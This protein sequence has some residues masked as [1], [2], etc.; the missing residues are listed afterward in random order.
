M[1]DNNLRKQ[2]IKLAYTNKELR[3]HLLPILKDAGST[4]M[5]PAGFDFFE[6]EEDDYVDKTDPNIR[7]FRNLKRDDRFRL[8]GK[9]FRVIKDEGYVK[10]VT[11]AGSAETKLF[12]AR[13]ENLNYVEGNPEV[14][15]VY[16]I[17]GIGQR[18]T[19]TPY[20]KPCRISLV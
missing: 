7:I 3:P 12:E 8:S 9:T 18:V 19:N 15:Y 16:Q 5:F 20:V 14:I 17:N 6:I 10:I 1:S 13:V 4:E 2:L 11:V